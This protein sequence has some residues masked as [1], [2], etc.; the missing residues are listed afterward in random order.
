MRESNCYAIHSKVTGEIV[1][2]VVGRYAPSNLKV[3]QQVSR[4]KG[5][6]P[7]LH[8]MFMGL[9]ANRPVDKNEQ[10]SFPYQINE[11]D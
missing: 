1:S 5:A 11:E 10:K 8:Y 2:V 4:V 9:K 7:R 6:D 3:D